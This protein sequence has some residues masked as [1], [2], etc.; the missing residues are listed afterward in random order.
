MLCGAVRMGFKTYTAGFQPVIDGR[1]RSRPLPRSSWIM[2]RLS[3][4]SERHRCEADAQKR[5]LHRRDVT[6]RA[7]AADRKDRMSR[8]AVKR[9]AQERAARLAARSRPSLSGQMMSG[10]QHEGGGKGVHGR[11]ARA[12]PLGGDKL[13]LMSAPQQEPLW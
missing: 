4:S 10:L 5:T 12:A 7:A 9:E 1:G 8:K 6:A 11:A 13:V 2:S 3:T